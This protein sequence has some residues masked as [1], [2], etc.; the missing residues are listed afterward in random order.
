MKQKLILSLL[1]AA[2]LS[3]FSA[4]AYEKS[5]YKVRPWEII[6]GLKPYSTPIWQADNGN[7]GSWKASNGGVLSEYDKTK[8]WGENVAKLALPSSGAVTITPPQPLVVK[9]ADGLDLWVF[10]P[11]GTIPQIDFM[12]VDA[13]GVTYRVPTS[14]CG[15]RWNKSRWWGAAAGLIPEKA[16]MTMMN[17]FAK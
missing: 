4:A 2:T 17:M 13:K 10:G 15:S 11:L 1:A 14:G 12:I 5:E 3:S 8:L 16:V 7:I 9:D 6:N